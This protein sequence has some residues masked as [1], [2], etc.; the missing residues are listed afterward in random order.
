MLCGKVEKIELVEYISNQLALCKITIDFDELYI[1][2]SFSELGKFLNANVQYE[3]AQDVWKGKPIT[4]VLNVANIVTVQTVDKVNSIRL[5]PED[6]EVR[7]CS[8]FDVKTVRRGDI[9]YGCI[10]FLSSYEIGKS[11]KTSWIDCTV[12]DARANSFILRIFTNTKCADPNDT[13]EDI[14]AAK[15]GKYIRFDLSNTK[16]GYQTNMVE[17]V[18]IPV[19]PP[20]EVDTAVT[21]INEAVE[22]DEELKAYMTKYDYI[23]TL[24]NIINCEFGYYLVEVA[25]EIV[26]SQMLQNISNIYDTK[27]L[28]R[29]AVTSRGY[30][31]TSKT[32]FS[33][34]VLNINKVLKSELGTCRDLLLM[35]DPLADE[36]ASRNKN[37]YMRISKFVKDVINE[38]RGLDV[39]EAIIDR[40]TLRDVSGGLL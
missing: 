5:I 10:G 6:A 1:F 18:N 21:I 30:L 17:L 16:Y 13:P 2:Y 31:L 32:N 7:E 35:L 23:N 4:I 20:K 34:P 25:S 24:R 39:Q 8:N 12:V 40:A 38:R 26:V 27:L 15:V 33:R 29:T 9:E 37:M 11:A 14:I 22:S 36:E 28:I 19:V 3:V